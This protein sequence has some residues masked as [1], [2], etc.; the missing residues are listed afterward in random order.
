M[1]RLAERGAQATLLDY[2]G[3]IDALQIRRDHA[4]GDDLLSWS[5]ASPWAA[6]IARLRCLRGIDTLTAVGLCAEITDFERFEHPK[7]LMSYVG[8]VPSEKSSGQTRRQGAITKSGSQHARR[9]LVEA[10]WHYRRP[11]RLGPP[12]SR[13]AKTTSPRR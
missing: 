10:A 8:L 12:R 13:P 9:L 11:P 5:P 1:V 4:R 2:L 7:L 3:A 6:D